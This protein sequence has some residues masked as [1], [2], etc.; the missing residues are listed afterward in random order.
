M[1]GDRIAQWLMSAYGARPKCGRPPE[2]FADSRKADIMWSVR[3]RLPLL[4]MDTEGK[5]WNW[6]ARRKKEPA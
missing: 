2:T 4:G 5:R 6:G 3:Q 1:A